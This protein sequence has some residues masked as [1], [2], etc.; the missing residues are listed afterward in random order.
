MSE[1]SVTFPNASFEAYPSTVSK[2]V[3]YLSENATINIPSRSD[4]YSFGLNKPNFEDSSKLWVELPHFAS[5]SGIIS[6]PLTFQLPLVPGATSYVFDS[7]PAGLSCSLSGLISGTPT[8][9]GLI[10]K[11]LV[12]TT[13]SSVLN[14]KVLFSILPVAASANPAPQTFTPNYS[15]DLYASR[16]DFDT[17]YLQN[18]NTGQAGSWYNV[19]LSPDTAVIESTKTAYILAKQYNEN[20]PRLLKLNNFG[21][22]VTTG[23]QLAVTPTVFAGSGSVGNTNGTGTAASWS[24]A[25]GGPYLDGLNNLY[26]I[27]TG[28]QR[29]RKVN[30][31][32]QVT[33]HYTH[34]PSSVYNSIV[35]GRAAI[36]S[37]ANFYVLLGVGSDF[38]GSVSG[39][40]IGKIT[41]TGVFSVLAGST[42]WVTA[43]GYADGIGTAAEF[44]SPRGGCFD[45]SGNLFVCDT[46]NNR[47]RKITPAGVVTTFAGSGF[48]GNVDGTGLAA[49]FANP[50]A[51]TSDSSDN[52]YVLCG[53]V[54]RKITSGAVVTTI[55]TTLASGNYSL[56]VDSSGNVYQC[57]SASHRILKITSGGVVS[58]FAGSTSGVSGSADGTGTS[59]RFKNPSLLVIDNSDNLYVFDSGNYT[60]RKINSSAVVTTFAGNPGTGGSTDGTAG[61]AT[62]G[63]FFFFGIN[64]SNGTMF[65]IDLFGSN[66][67]LR[68]ISPSAVVTSLSSPVSSSSGYLN[69]PFNK[70]R[71]SFGDRANFAVTNSNLLYFSD[72]QFNV[73][74]VFNVANSVSS[75]FV[76]KVYG[77]GIKGG[78]DGT[79]STAV[80]QASGLAVDSSGNV[81]FC[82]SQAHVIQKLTPSGNVT[83]VAGLAYTVG[84]SDGTGS[85]AR[86]DTPIDVAVDSSGNVFVSDAGNSTIRRITPAGVVT[87]VAGLAGTPHVPGPYQN[88]IGSRAR[89]YEY[90][91]QQGPRGLFVSAEDNLYLA[92][93]YQFSYGGQ[94]QR[95]SKVLDP[96]LNITSSNLFNWSVNATNNFQ[97]TTQNTF[98][99]TY[100]FD[101]PLYTNWASPSLPAVSSYS[102]SGLP[103]GVVIN[104][105]TGLL[106]GAPTVV[107]VYNSVI[108]STQTYGSVS[109]GLS[110]EVLAGVPA[111]EI[112][113]PSLRKYS[114]SYWKEFSTLKR[115]DI[116]LVPNSQQV[117]FPWGESNVTYDMSYWGEPNVSVPTLPSPP[118]GFK[119]K[120]YIGKN[121]GESSLP[122]IY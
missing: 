106:T 35:G 10:E 30:S 53:S 32:A 57:D 94:I 27:D 108:T 17:F 23:N 56:A 90:L 21:A 96:F 118:S 80:F 61:N 107:G 52:L 63:S 79:S 112:T 29:I 91:G 51:I 8:V 82:D 110:I 47:I 89:F 92:E 100:Y 67:K 105:S 103:P 64:K 14:E 69:G 34:S 101:S 111:I 72:T 97:I 31:S 3:D 65:A 12:V 87:T 122:I 76:G 55:A 44:N 19:D 74:R 9:S 66:F 22:G 102:A 119:Y 85:A 50:V 43:S 95:I 117:K 88:G 120:Y 115:G 28:N 59:A 16:T 81:Y 6:N 62:F 13:A 39:R 33:T 68:S 83:T 4:L 45:S 93:S 77:V 109:K 114:Q 70:T 40:S 24:A 26:L 25:A 75:T 84:S 121:I 2:T 78:V 99:T 46:T 36:D 86:F 18:L 42:G 60:I 116:V 98:R 73:V 15:G 41:S 58:T 54:L 7:L 104:S 48:N 37:S 71:I 11:T 1:Y 38:T 20:A 5:V 49:S 113:R